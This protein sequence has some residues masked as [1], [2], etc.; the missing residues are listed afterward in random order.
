MAAIVADAL[1]ERQPLS[2]AHNARP[3]AS[4]SVVASDSELLSISTDSPAIV[5]RPVHLLLHA[6]GS[7]PGNLIPCPSN[8]ASNAQ[9]SPRSTLSPSPDLLSVPAALHCCPSP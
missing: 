8:R 7:A 2:G 4:A 9:P 5:A 6:S 1:R 3:F